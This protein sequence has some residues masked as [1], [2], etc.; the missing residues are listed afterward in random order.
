[1]T[2]TFT[3]MTLSLTTQVEVILRRR[4]RQLKRDAANYHQMPVLVQKVINTI[5]QQILKNLPIVNENEEINENGEI[6]D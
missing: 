1:M 5:D 4:A 3:S 2:A 6:N